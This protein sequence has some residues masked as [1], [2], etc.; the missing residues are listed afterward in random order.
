MNV[1]STWFVLYYNSEDKFSEWKFFGQWPGED[2]VDAIKN[3][4]IEGKVASTAIRVFPLTAGKRFARGPW[5]VGEEADE[6][7]D[8]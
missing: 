2:E 3:S 5:V 1:Q 7:S 6:Q 8:S 4:G